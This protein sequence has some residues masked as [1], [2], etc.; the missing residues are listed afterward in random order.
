MMEDR[1]LL[2]SLMLKKLRLKFMN[3]RRKMILAAR[4]TTKLQFYLQQQNTN[5]SCKQFPRSKLKSTVITMRIKQLKPFTKTTLD[6]SSKTYL[7]GILK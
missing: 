2:N 3:S 5:P 6:R 1:W 7:L 4:G